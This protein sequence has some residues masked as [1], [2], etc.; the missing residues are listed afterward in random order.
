MRITVLV[1]ND[2]TDSLTIDQ[3][4]APVTVAP[5]QNA[6]LEVLSTHPVTI[7]VVSP[8][9]AEPATPA[10][11]VV[12]E[13]GGI[14]GPIDPASVPAPASQ[15]AAVEPAPPSFEGNT[16]AVVVPDGAPQEV[17]DVAKSLL[18]TNQAIAQSNVAV[19]DAE[20]AKQALAKAQ[21]DADAAV[22][23][24][25]KQRTSTALLEA[26]QNA[27]TTATS[28]DAAL[29]MADHH[30][31]TA[32]EAA[33]KVQ[34]LADD[35]NHP[36]T[37]DHADL[38]NNLAQAA[39]DAVAVAK[40]EDP[41]P[42]S[43][44]DGEKPSA[45]STEDSQV[46]PP[47]P[48]DAA[49]LTATDGSTPAPTNLGDASG[50]TPI[51]EEHAAAAANAPAPSDATVIAVIDTLMDNDAALTA[52]GEISIDHLNAALVAKGFSPVAPN[53]PVL[54]EA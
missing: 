30:A 5:G 46:A 39:S 2:Q 35:P 18:A 23:D 10:A 25:D 32:A 6:T 12:A 27:N 54:A 26:Q 42:V 3:G 15:P 38:A 31:D 41:A 44:S 1:E 21:A 45:T 13:A 53:H 47:A 17:H 16:G 20:E 29:E 14:T 36:M 48:S 34:D 22:S 9:I 51:T 24:A 4:G 43:Q 33:T 37:Q 7:S 19:A 8:T 50:S 40:G 52:Q 11:P 28:R 49:P